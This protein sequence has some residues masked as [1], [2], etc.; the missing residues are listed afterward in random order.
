MPTQQIAQTRY[1]IDSLNFRYHIAGLENI[2]YNRS[3]YRNRSEDSGE[4]IEIASRFIALANVANTE[5]KKW[6]F[7]L[8]LTPIDRTR[9]SELAQRTTDETPIPYP[10][11]GLR[12]ENQQKQFFFDMNSSGQT[13]VRK[14]KRGRPPL[15]K[16]KVEIDQEKCWFCLSSTKV[17]QELIISVGKEVYLALAK[18]GVVNDHMLIL[19]VTHHRNCAI[20]PK[21]I[22]EEM[23]LYKDAMT[24]FY[25]TTSRVPVFFDRNYKSD[26]CQLQVIPVPRHKASLLKKVFQVCTISFV[27]RRH[28]ISHSLSSRNWHLNMVSS[29]LN[30][31]KELVSKKWP[32]KGLY[33]S[34]WNCR[35]E[36]DCSIESRKTSLCSLA[37]K[38][39]LA[40]NCSMSKN[41]LTGATACW[42]RTSKTDY[43]AE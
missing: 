40:K 18:G 19:P 1:S 36:K 28:L 14:S 43:P 20:L 22:V 12:S 8:S 41:E 21:P 30:Y 5:G 34:T 24:K 39:L 38:F 10:K 25:A 32:L 42:T 16:A 31:Q 35:L 37:E 17:A 27:H 11:D 33:T 2:H 29:L 23:A 15:K 3:P 9:L 7:A 26:H 6:I 13:E 4:G